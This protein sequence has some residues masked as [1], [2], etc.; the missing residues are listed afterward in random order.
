MGQHVRVG[1]TQKPKIKWY[2]DPT[3][4]QGTT[5]AQA[6]SVISKAYSEQD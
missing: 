2:F 6:M 4:N 3:D 5:T 1:V